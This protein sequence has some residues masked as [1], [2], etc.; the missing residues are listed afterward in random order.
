M[1]IG[2]GV[3]FSL[4]IIVLFKNTVSIIAIGI[5]SI[6]L[7]IAVNYPLHFLAHFKHIKAK[8]ETLRDLINP[9]L[10]GNIT[11][12]GAFLSLLFISSEAMHDLGLFSALLLV[13]TMIFVLVFLPHIL[14]EK[15]RGKE[16][17][18]SETTTGGRRLLMRA[19][20]GF[21]PENNKVLVI[22]FVLATI[23]LFVFSFGTKF[24][25]DM[26]NINYMTAEQRQTKIGRA[27][28]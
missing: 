9:L 20:T 12:V 22:A 7:G 23:V 13:G 11:T 24:D 15:K 28:V 1:S 3:L 10:I 19:I 18:S 25:V 2:F 27:H 21:S 6:I 8:E 26:H 16:I 14:S 17:S 5:S 4:G